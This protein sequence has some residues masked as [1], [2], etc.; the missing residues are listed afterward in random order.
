MNDE[1]RFAARNESNDVVHNNRVDLGKNNSDETPSQVAKVDA[2]S[3]KD[4]KRRSN[5][6]KKNKKE[7][8]LAEARVVCGAIDTSSA[9]SMRKR[10]EQ[11]K[12]EE[13]MKLVARKSSQKAAEKPETKWIEK[14]DE[15]DSNRLN[16]NYDSKSESNKK[17]QPSEDT[18][19]ESKEEPAKEIDPAEPLASNIEM[20]KEKENG[21]KDESNDVVHNNRVDL[22]KNNSYETPSQVAKVD[23]VTNK[24]VKSRSNGRKKDKK[25]DILAEARAVCGAIDTSSARSMRMRVK[26]LKAEKKKELMAQK[27]SQEATEKPETKWTQKEEDEEDSN[28]LNENYD[29]KRE[30]NKDNQPSEDTTEDS[31][32]EPAKE[33]DPVASNIEMTEEKENGTKEEATTVETVNG[34]AAAEVKTPAENPPITVDYAVWDCSERERENCRAERVRE[35]ARMK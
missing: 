32:M 21:T 35:C 15:E 31:K 11:L 17:N 18:T 14:Q 7:E 27:S 1:D 3:N 5:G 16:E 29:S 25:E 19:E 12:T 2:F 8:M 23:A 22:G 30:S 9:R 13:K 4:V 24:D 28:R 26:Q 33:V 6:R 10:V 20:T 34:T